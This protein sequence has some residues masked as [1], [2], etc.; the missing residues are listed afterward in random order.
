MIDKTTILMLAPESTKEGG[1]GIAV[2][3]DMLTEELSNKYEICRVSTMKYSNFIDKV[4]RLMKG[5]VIIFILSLKKDKLIAHINTAHNRSFI[6][7]AIFCKFCKLLK[8]PVVLHL[9]SSEFHIYFE[10]S[11]VKNQERIRDVFKNAEKVIVLSNSWKEWYIKNIE[12]REPTVI[13][14]G[15]YDLSNSSDNVSSRDNN[16]LFLG[17]LGDRKGTYDLIKAFKLVLDR[18]SDVKL[19]LAGDGEIDECKNLAISLGIEHKIDFPGWIGANEKKILLNN[20]KIFVLPSYNEGFPLSILEAMSNRLP[21]I[22]TNIGGIPEELDDTI[23]G[24]L[25]NPGD[26]EM[27]AVHILK[28]LDDK[29]LCNSIGLQARK[30]FEDNFTIEKIIQD[31]ELTYSEIYKEIKCL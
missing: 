17:R 19:I 6:R 20:C 27:L 29:D 1:G 21:I 28:I 13:Y 9:H 12:Q 22:S 30:K 4:Y 8:I 23:S 7:K 31:I 3:A 2:Y 14:N 11:T 25:I 16:I 26:V 24:Y 15:M 18:K 10:N 5:L